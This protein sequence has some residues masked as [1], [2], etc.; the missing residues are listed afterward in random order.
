MLLEVIQKNLFGKVALQAH[1]SQ[2]TLENTLLTSSKTDDM[3]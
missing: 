2:C 1:A 3:G